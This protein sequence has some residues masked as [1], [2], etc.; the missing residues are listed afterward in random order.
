MQSDGTMGPVITSLSN[1]GFKTNPAAT[2]IIATFAG[3]FLMFFG[4]MLGSPILVSMILLIG[5][6]YFVYGLMAGYTHYDLPE[7]GL[8]KSFESFLSKYFKNHRDYSFYPFTSIKS[9]SIT[10]DLSRSL[11]EVKTLKIHLDRAPNTLWITNQINPDQFELFSQAFVETVN[12]YNQGAE[13]TAAQKAKTLNLEENVVLP[14]EIAPLKVDAESF[15]E[16]SIPVVNPRRKIK[17]KGGFYKT[18]WAKLLTV[19]FLIMSIIFLVLWAGG[20]LGPTHVFRLLIIILPGT[21]YM[22]YRVFMKRDN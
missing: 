17:R 6:I 7:K 19:I 16:K 8:S 20:Y 21:M 1:R 3:M 2:I 18:F 22:F 10:K 5:G 12:R 14:R 11:K 13:E 4:I 15:S 9:F